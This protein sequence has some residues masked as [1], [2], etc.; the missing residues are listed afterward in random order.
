VP[1]LKSKDPIGRLLE[2][3]VFLQQI[4]NGYS[5]DARRL[6]TAAHEE[7]AARLTYYAPQ[8]VVG[9]YRQLRLEKFRKD[10]EGVSWGTH[11]EIY[12]NMRK[13]L[14]ALGVDQSRTDIAGV[15]SNFKG[16]SPDR[17]KAIVESKPFEGRILKDHLNYMSA[18]EAVNIHKQVQLGLLQ[19]DDL[20][21]LVRRI[22]GTRGPSGSF[23]GGVWEAST[24]NATAVART[25]TNHISNEALLLGYQ[26]QGDVI[27]GVR[28][29]AT[30]DE[31]T[32][33]LCASLDQ[34]VWL[35]GDP[36]IRVPPLHFQCRSSLLPHF[37]GIDYGKQKYE[38]WLREQDDSE[39]ETILG[40]GRAK[41]FRGGLSLRDMITGDDRIVR[42]STLR[43]KLFRRIDPGPQAI[44]FV[45][46]AVGSPMYGDYQELA[47]E[48]FDGQPITGALITRNTI[49]GEGPWRV[50]FYNEGQPLHHF[51]GNSVEELR[52]LYINKLGMVERP[53]FATPKDLPEETYMGPPRGKLADVFTEEELRL[54]RLE[55]APQGVPDYLDPIE[56]KATRVRSRSYPEEWR[57]TGDIQTPERIEKR[58]GWINRHHN[59]IREKAHSDWGG[60]NHDKKLVIVLGPPAAG[61]TTAVAGKLGRKYK[62]VMPD[63]DEIKGYIP[64][65]D[66]GLNAQGVH[67]ESTMVLD[68][69]WDRIF[70]AGEN[71]VFQG[72]GK[73]KSNI[74]DFIEK[75]RKFGYTVDLYLNDL[76]TLT[77]AGRSI[78]RFLDTKRLVAPEFIINVVKD[79]PL[80]TFSDIIEEFDRDPILDGRWGH[81][82]NDTPF[83]ESPRKVRIG[84]NAVDLSDPYVFKLLGQKPGAQI[85]MFAHKKRVSRIWELHERDHPD[86]EEFDDI[87]KRG[88]HYAFRVDGHDRPIVVDLIEHKDGEGLWMSIGPGGNI[89]NVPDTHRD[90]FF[91]A[92][93][94]SS[95]NVERIGVAALREIIRDI[96]VD[97]PDRKYL[98]GERVTGARGK[99][100]DER[101]MRIIKQKPAVLFWDVGDVEISSSVIKTELGDD[102]LLAAHDRI[103]GKFMGYA[104]IAPRGGVLGVKLIE[105]LPEFRRKGVATQLLTR[106]K[107]V[108]GDRK[109]DWGSAT[110]QGKALLK[111]KGVD[112]VSLPD[113]AR[114]EGRVT[115]A[116]FKHANDRLAY[117]RQNEA[118][119]R[120]GKWG[121]KEQRS[122]DSNVALMQEHIQ[123]YHIEQ[124][125][126]AD[127]LP[128][129]PRTVR[130]NLQKIENDREFSVMLIK[131]Q[132]TP[133]TAKRLDNLAEKLTNE[134]IDSMLA[135]SDFSESAEELS[136]KVDVV[137]TKRAATLPEPVPVPAPATTATKVPLPQGLG[138]PVL[139]PESER[140]KYALKRV[141][142][143]EKKNGVI[144]L[145]DVSQGTKSTFVDDTVG[146][147]VQFDEDAVAALP[148]RPIPVDKIVFGSDAQEFVESATVRR[149]IND[150]NATGG[151]GVAG[152]REMLVYRLDDGRYLVLDGH[153]RSVAAI[154][155]QEPFLNARVLND[156]PTAQ[157]QD[158]FDAVTKPGPTV[159]IL[160]Q[161]EPT[162]DFGKPLDTSVGY[163]KTQRTAIKKAI[164][165]SDNED[166]ATGRVA[167]AILGD[168]R[169][170]KFT[171]NHWSPEADDFGVRGGQEPLPGGGSRVI[172]SSETS[173]LVQRALGNISQ[174]RLNLVGREG[175]EAIKV[176]IHEISHAASAVGRSRSEF[177]A[178]FGSARQAR[179]VFLEE[180]LVEY[181]AQMTMRQIFGE[182][183]PFYGSYRFEV[184]QV[185][186]FAQRF[187]EEAVDKLFEMTA[188]ARQ[189]HWYE[190][191]RNDLA[192]WLAKG[193]YNSDIGLMDLH[194]ELAQFRWSDKAL[195]ETK[196]LIAA[197][198]A[199]SPDEVATVLRSWRKAAEAQGQKMTGRQIFLEPAEGRRIKAAAVLDQKTGKV[200]EGG[201]HVDAYYIATGKSEAWVQ[202]NFHK[203]RERYI[204]GFTDWDGNFLNRG[205][206]RERV[207]E[208]KQGKPMFDWQTGEQIDF[209]PH[210]LEAPDIDMGVTIKYQGTPV[211]YYQYPSKTTVDVKAAIRIKGGDP[212]AG[213]GSHSTVLEEAWK[214]GHLDNDFVRRYLRK[215]VS[216]EERAT[217]EEGFLVNGRWVTKDAAADAIK[218]A[219]KEMDK[220]QGIVDRV[221]T[222]MTHFFAD[223][224]SYADVPDRKY[225]HVAQTARAVVH[226]K[227]KYDTVNDLAEALAGAIA[228]ADPVIGGS[229]SK[230]R[231][232]KVNLDVKRLGKN[233]VMNYNPMSTE[234]NV[235]PIHSQALRMI[236]EDMQLIHTVTPDNLQPFVNVLGSLIHEMYHSSSSGVKYTF[237]SPIGTFL[238]EG[239]V[240]LRAR[241]TLASLV[242]D[243]AEAV[244]ENYSLYKREVRF[245]EWLE[246]VR[247][248]DFLDEVYR[249]SFNRHELIHEVIEEQLTLALQR[250]KL[251]MD[252]SGVDSSDPRAL[253][254]F[255]QKREALYNDLV[256]TNKAPDLATMTKAQ[257]KKLW[258]EIIK[259]APRD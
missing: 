138:A 124:E 35:W 14:I 116:Q 141:L 257:L 169:L 27:K 238:E 221:Y 75:A 120:A 232:T 179:H 254:A 123:R 97:F 17:F 191:L 49:P 107:Q 24:R 5:D 23:E 81:F 47:G 19:G 61:K 40:K 154:Y 95:E 21:K 74:L 214:S 67:V 164:L 7:I 217:I 88:H 12:K 248:A 122:F 108:A 235:S 145:R 90:A 218:A 182:N 63:A 252:F 117:L 83:G 237:I 212:L 168:K 187:G 155:R 135:A 204:E 111:A 223:R 115:E 225:G 4:G 170:D 189:R 109:I 112:V 129:L 180:G 127:R 152:L 125:L 86:F 199:G 184:E 242:G 259:D 71:V 46:P 207:M 106:I 42:L 210:H 219:Q 198:D 25:A 228:E 215:K 185:T 246:R 10:M 84:R 157:I 240:E 53:F 258:P 48:L 140:I 208:L 236:I 80:K 128:N 167:R 51:A 37:P 133:A 244:A 251:V 2:N 32:T 241:R 15:F 197:M 247:G 104:D 220:A 146:T 186:A 231:F 9:R 142:N 114:I 256:I 196:S 245:M 194:Q 190:T 121:G 177:A 89:T 36:N 68:D 33:L 173:A 55:P 64:E 213:Y 193:K 56:V 62:A 113:A 211:T 143:V 76:D 57:N 206:A 102:I 43:Q 126:F 39:I 243:H 149:Y 174:G 250:N 50:T 58:I 195:R 119:I 45:P 137:L 85:E 216:V 230:F 176:V 100:A 79:N 118:V 147:A 255:V 30:L 227:T 203:L 93:F 16:M 156:K 94:I 96:K 41:L 222:K 130:L 3:T 66:D 159:K 69:V 172:F 166:V 70:A 209:V 72:V 65:F 160:R 253:L 201:I 132:V 153:H 78:G 224:G 29:S 136:E 105:V 144:P 163:S 73:T 151:E 150:L 226:P 77:T 6:L 131:E 161:P 59:E 22:R 1:K 54:A 20:G 18:T 92:D 192:E 171:V 233:V 103:T 178:V 52:E 158:A 234:I 148:T 28:F 13:D 183:V 188:A 249:A 91:Q 165:E 239:L 8:D 26:A 11:Q 99:I 202:A 87:D 162:R 175:W 181:R 38:D 31:K 110:P 98:I 60:L 139:A 205:E 229:Y 101:D 34:T 200:Y 82:V 134:D 44:S